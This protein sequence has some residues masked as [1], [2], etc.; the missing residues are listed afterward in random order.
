MA[1]SDDFLDLIEDDDSQASFRRERVWKVLVIDDDPAVH[2][3][4]RFALYDYTLNGQGIEIVSAHSAREGRDLLRAHPDAAVVLLDVVMETEN[5]GLELV[6]FIRNELE[7][8]PFASS[9]AP[10]S[11]A[12][13]RSAASSSITTSTTTRPRR[14]S[15][16]TGC[17]RR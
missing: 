2:D 7:T 11:P 3:G 16:P 4:T 5:A 9:C 12:R 6:D 14:S 13:R 8:K 10:A 17:S 15:P 1:D